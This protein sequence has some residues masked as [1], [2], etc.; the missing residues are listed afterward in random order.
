M[1]SWY[2]PAET[3]IPLAAM[4]WA[5][6]PLQNDFEKDLARN[7]EGRIVALAISGRALLS[8]LLLILK[9]N[10][11]H[12]KDEVL[13]PGYTCYSVAASVAR[14]GLKVNV[15]DLDPATLNPDM[16]SFKKAFNSRTLAVI[17]QHL[18]GVPSRFS[19]I[20]DLAKETGVPVIE[21]AAQALGGST[22][23]KPLGTLG[24]FG[25]FSFGRGKP[26]PLG[27]GGALVAKD[28]GM[29]KDMHSE[30]PRLCYSIPFVTLAARIF[31][32]EKVYRIMETLPLG[33]GET[34]FDPGFTIGPMPISASRMGSLSLNNLERLNEHRRSIAQIYQKMF[35]GN[36]TL[37][38][39]DSDKAVYTRF[40]LV[41]S[42][43]VISS[44]LMR[45]GCRRMYPK[46]IKDEPEISRFLAQ[47]SLNTPGA[48]EIAEK[49]VTLPTHMG[50]LP[51]IAQ[52]IAVK[53]YVELA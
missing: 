39:S 3:R 21:D 5:F 32:H 37:P 45:L 30:Q 46:A 27:C 36:M 33:L 31:S 16:D 51:P 15:Y 35:P 42:K 25:L 49:L 28:P 4:F 53:A 48:R 18:F 34:V 11:L 19:D 17:V 9:K 2:P 50:I 13:L 14:A 22:G 44:L 43:G 24:D 26:L 6:F 41:K 29:L 38:I 47:G 52:E 23:G 12:K 1:F 10:D 8:Q 7:F 20:M 40:P